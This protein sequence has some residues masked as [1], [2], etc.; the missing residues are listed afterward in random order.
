MLRI[1]Q[2]VE[3][4]FDPVFGE[5]YSYTSRNVPPEKPVNKRERERLEKYK[6]VKWTSDSF[7]GA[8]PYITAEDLF[9]SESFQKAFGLE[10][11]PLDKLRRNKQ[12]PKE[13]D[14]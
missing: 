10:E 3:D 5:R 12:T 4:L 9:A 1:Q 6:D 8:R 11:N 2:F 13:E 14:S 7:W